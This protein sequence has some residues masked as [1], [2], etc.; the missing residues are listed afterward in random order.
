M[1]LPGK[2]LMKS[3]RVLLLLIALAAVCGVFTYSC[4]TASEVG[5]QNTITAAEAQRLVE[6]YVH[7]A[8]TALPPQARLEKQYERI[9]DCD[10]PT[11]HGP[12][13]R[14]GASI[15]YWIRDLPKDQ[16]QTYLNA[17]LQY[18]TQHGWKLL[19]DSRPGYNYIWVEKISDGFRMSITA[20]INGDLNIGTDSPC[21][22][23]N[24]TPE[25]KP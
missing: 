4:I 9:S 23:P 10:Q 2:P 20:N 18:W 17:A 19:T 5:M 6:A 14:V 13:G 8:M 7:E 21:V 12:R 24:G 22:W 3:R 16:N 25:P 1:T 11:D 15:G